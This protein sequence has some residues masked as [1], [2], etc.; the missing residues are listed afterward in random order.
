M[1]IG[2]FQKS[3]VS[4]LRSFDFTR[5]D[6]SLLLLDPK[7]C[8]MELIPEQVKILPV[9]IDP[10]YFSSGG[11]AVISMIKKKH[12]KAALYRLISCLLWAFD[13]G[14]GA[15]F[16]IKCVPGL[17]QEYDAIIDY[18]GQH[19]LYYMID[20]LNANKYISFFHSDY[21]K[22][23]Y[24]EK[25]DRKYYQKADAIITV[26]EECVSSLKEVFPEYS[27]KI[28]CVENI[29][30]PK[31]VYLFAPGSNPFKDSFDGI[32]LIT[33][34]RVCKDK[35]LDLALDAAKRLTDDG[36][37]F[38]WYFV[39]PITDEEFLNDYFR[40]YGKPEQIV[41]LGPTNN[42]YDYIRDSA[43]VVHPSRFEG[44]AVAVEEAKIMRKP[45]VATNYSTV[46]N[47]IM[48]G[49]T[50][51]IVEMN[52][53]ALY[54]GIKRMIDDPSLREHIVERQSQL[55]FGN[56]SEVQKVYRLIDD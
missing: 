2:G 40:L 32:R 53:E 23:R 19:L 26:S 28:F 25:T 29:V 42:P 18:N 11:K 34:G 47:Q 41:L 27:H 35:G 1:G 37:H 21:K 5:Y 50:G 51:L 54:K 14:M 46:S 30:S 12:Y 24:Y 43:I 22:W 45:I 52:G 38:R 16:M 13:K 6:V 56:E 36:Y 8:F 44:K 15:S 3:L 48:D 10:D 20:K 17:D 49:E 31:T 4:L 9:V 33:I 7:G 39:G 55:C